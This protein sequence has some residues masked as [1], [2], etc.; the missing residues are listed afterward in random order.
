VGQVVKLRPGDRVPPGA[1]GQLSPGDAQQQAV[2][3]RQ[4][5]L[6]DRARTAERQQPLRRLIVWPA[7]ASARTSSQPAALGSGGVK[8][9][10]AYRSYEAGSGTRQR[11]G[12][13]RPGPAANGL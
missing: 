13:T 7:A 4:R 3:P 10:H 8:W 12:K 9:W 6:T 2:Q 11:A 5:Q 1:P